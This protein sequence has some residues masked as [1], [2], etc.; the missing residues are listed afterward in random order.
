MELSYDFSSIFTFSSVDFIGKDQY[1]LSV[2]VLIP[3]STQLGL[4]SH[5]YMST[6]R[7]QNKRENTDGLDPTKN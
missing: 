5:A 7:A 2:I 6:I 4:V 3:I 1:C